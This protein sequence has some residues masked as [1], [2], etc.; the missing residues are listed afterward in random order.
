MTERGGRRDV[1][2]LLERTSGFVIGRGLKLGVRVRCPHGS[3]LYLRVVS[4]E[5][6]AGEAAAGLA[7][8]TVSGDVRVHAA[9]GGSMRVQS[10]SGDVYLAIKPGDACTSTRAR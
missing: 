5:L 8:T 10:V 1:A 6:S 7:V 2:M 9:G 4:E 3:D